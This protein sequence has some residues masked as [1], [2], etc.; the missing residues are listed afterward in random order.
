MKF[1]EKGN[2]K[3]NKNK[4]KKKYTRER[5]CFSFVSTLIFAHTPFVR[6]NCTSFFKTKN[7]IDLISNNKAQG[8]NQQVSS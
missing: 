4:Q 3:T 5:A 8:K 7:V 2:K 6:N 1:P